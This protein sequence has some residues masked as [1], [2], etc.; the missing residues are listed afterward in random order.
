[1][2]KSLI[3]VNERHLHDSLLNFHGN[4]KPSFMASHS[5]MHTH[6]HTPLGGVAYPHWEQ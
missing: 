1:M 3:T 6:I 2:N 4:Q 5:P